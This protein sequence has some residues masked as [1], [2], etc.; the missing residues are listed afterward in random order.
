MIEE[1]KFERNFEFD[2]LLKEATD[3]V[4]QELAIED[5]GWINLS[6]T[7]SE[8][9]T[10][11]ERV[12]MLKRSRIYFYK[13]PLAKQAIRLWTDYTF[14]SGMTW[15]AEDTNTQKIINQFWNAKK[16]SR[17]LSAEGQRRSSN[18]LLVDGEV[19]F[20]LFL[21]SKDQGAA[22]RLI[23]PLEITEI[24]SNPEDKDDVKFYKR[25]W[26]TPQ[27]SPQ[28]AYYRNHLNIENE[29][30]KDAMGS[31]R[32]AESNSPIVYHSAYNTLGLRG[33]PLLV[34]A[35][36]WIKQYRRFL[37]SRVAIM[38]ALAKFAWKEKLKGNATQVAAVQAAIEGKQVP[39]G[40]NLIENMAIDTQPIRTDSNARNAYDDGRMLKL[41]V[42][43]AVGIPEQ[44]FGDISIGN[45][46]TAKTVELPMLK[47]FT[48]YQQVWA[49][50]YK[51]I[52][53]IVLEHARIDPSKW[54]IDRDF[55]PIAPEDVAAAAQAMLTIVQAF[56]QF[57]DSP[58]VQQQALMA[59]GINNVAE[60]IKN[61]TKGQKEAA[62]DPFAR[63]AKDL[64][65]CKK[66]LQEA[67]ANGGNGYRQGPL[68]EMEFVSDD[69]RKAVFAN[70]NNGGGN[71]SKQNSEGP[72]SFK[73]ER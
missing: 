53:E 62:G 47:M 55:P 11:S 35:L 37:V 10:E 66:Q 68:R 49:D 27:G 3:T 2:V 32:K 43:S 57:V 6:A 22:V 12:S 70:I 56:P 14:G 44:Y 20:A 61:L 4:E 45:L 69:Q 65:E 29:S 25:A 5:R 72:G 46:A 52:D 40:S 31:E 19:F 50:T 54:Y 51:S 39:A 9:L 34:P 7:S 30:C 71:L 17:I 42:A 21:G 15:Q 67:I 59:L 73:Q 18:K 1:T 36:D 16:N 23:D 24:I 38:L 58:D 8:I 28:Q 41:Q 13:D 63:L 60:V 64:R 48:S 33:V 26:S